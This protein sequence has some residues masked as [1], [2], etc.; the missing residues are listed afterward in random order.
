MVMLDSTIAGAINWTDIG[1]VFTGFGGLVPDIVTM[2]INFV[3]LLIILAIVGF[4]LKFLHAIVAV[5]E[6]AVNIFK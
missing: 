5:I 4:V 6:G 2:I 1:T 3:P